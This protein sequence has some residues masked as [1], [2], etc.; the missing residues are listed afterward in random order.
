[1]GIIAKKIPSQREGS[2]LEHEEEVGPIHFVQRNVRL[3]FALDTGRADDPDALVHEVADWYCH[4]VLAPTGQFALLCFVLARLREFKAVPLIDFVHVAMRDR[5]QGHHP[6]R[7]RDVAAHHPQEEAVDKI[8]RLVHDVFRC[9]ELLRKRIAKDLANDCI[10]EPS[11]QARVADLVVESTPFEQTLERFWVIHDEPTT[12]ASEDGACDLPTVVFGH[13]LVAHEKAVMFRVA[14]CICRR[15]GQEATSLAHRVHDVGQVEITVQHE[16][17]QIAVVERCAQGAFFVRVDVVWRLGDRILSLMTV[18]RMVGIVPPSCL[19]SLQGVLDRA[20]GAQR[21]DERVGR[22]NARVLE[23]V[24]RD[25]V[26]ILPGMQLHSVHT[27]P[28]ESRM[29][30]DLFTPFQILAILIE[31]HSNLP[32]DRMVRRSRLDD[33]LHLLRETQLDELES[34]LILFLWGVANPGV[35]HLLRCLCCGKGHGSLLVAQHT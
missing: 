12:F 29:G 7:N 16:V 35:L 9:E 6:I 2:A 11:V 5:E 8:I 15:L 17:K 30:G 18:G 28:R 20:P 23:P 22:D 13:G 1:M 31:D 27:Q 24:Y 26:A 25:R 21:E 3:E 34:G 14:G 32:V 33:A 19:T 10:Q 4:D